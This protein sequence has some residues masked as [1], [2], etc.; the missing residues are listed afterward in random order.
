MVTGVKM[1]SGRFA[2]WK[3]GL[4]DMSFLLLGDGGSVDPLLL[5]SPSDAEPCELSEPRFR[6]DGLLCDFEDNVE[7]GCLL[8]VFEVRLMP[9]R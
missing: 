9:R 5:P 3:L 6:V 8:E 1:D 2:C 7:L 4:G